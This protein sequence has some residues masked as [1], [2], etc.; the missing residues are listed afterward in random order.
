MC[1]YIVGGWVGVPYC[2]AAGG[3]EGAHHKGAQMWL[4]GCWLGAAH[5]WRELCNGLLRCAACCAVQV[6]ALAVDTATVQLFTGS[7][8]GTMRVWSCESGQASLGWG[9]WWGGLVCVWVGRGVWCV[10]VG[11]ELRER[12]GQPGLGCQLGRA[13]WTC[14]GLWVGGWGG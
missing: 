2:G 11:G 9:C 4:L 10:R 5:G 12:A 6:T 13:Q 8:D 14:M 1:V 7:Q 3:A